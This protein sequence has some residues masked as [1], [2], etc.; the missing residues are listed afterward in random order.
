[1]RFHPSRR[2]AL[3]R[4]LSA[5][6]SL[7]VPLL[8][9]PASVRGQVPE[10]LADS[11]SVVDTILNADS[12]ASPPVLPEAARVEID[13]LLASY[14]DT[15]NALGII[16]TGMAEAEIATEQIRLAGR[17]STNL[18]AMIRGAYAVLNTIDPN[19]VGSGPGL[20]YGFRRAA[21]AVVTHIGLATAVDSI[22]ETLRFHAEYVAR[23]SRSA[24]AIADEAI[25]TAQE[26]QRA[27]SPAAA[28][29]LLRVLRR[30]VREMAWGG[31]RDRDGRIGYSDGELGLAQATYHL[32]LVR[33]MTAPPQ[34]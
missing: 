3:A 32:E 2:A 7:A 19:V 6:T 30:Q 29:G 33:R 8:V 15:P 9:L 20:G 31:D 14:F 25:A 5:V 34:G 27:S 13:Y 11:A 17:D 1:M 12:V 16:P 26:L 21:E 4:R 18:N 24:S 10:Q 23:A 22:P 28:R